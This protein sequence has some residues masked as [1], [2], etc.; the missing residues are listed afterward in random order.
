M[1]DIGGDML[2]GGTANA[3][4]T[5]DA[6]FSA[7]EDD[8]SGFGFPTIK[9]DTGSADGDPAADSDGGSP[10]GTDSAASSQEDS[11]AP[12]VDS[13][14]PLD[15]SGSSADTAPPVVDAGPMVPTLCS[16]AY[17]QVGCCVGNTAYWCNSPN[18]PVSHKN[19]ATA[20]Q[21]C[22]WDLDTAYYCVDPPAT[23]GAGHPINCQ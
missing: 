12:A 21:V 10:P 20:G 14:T 8:A 15:D 22:G 16:E 13:S 1:L 3:R 4:D 19:C 5:T 7:S 6:A 17:Q 11:S 2:D 18:G 23:T 9:T